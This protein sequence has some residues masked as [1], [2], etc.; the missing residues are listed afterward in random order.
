MND[1]WK[2]RLWEDLRQEPQPDQIVTA[3]EVIT[4]LVHHLL[5]ELGRHRRQV[6]LDLLATPGWDPVRLAESIGARPAAIVRLAEEGRSAGL[7]PSPPS[8]VR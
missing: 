7:S 8:P 1:A 3:G 6:V 2:Q 4:E 5:P